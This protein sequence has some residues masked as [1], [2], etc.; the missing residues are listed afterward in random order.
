MGTTTNNGWTYPESTDLV[1][2]GATAIQ[3]LADAID[4]TLGVYAP[5]TS[6]LTLINTT[7][8]S[9]VA[10]QSL[11]AD[12]FTS[13]YRN[14]RMVL[15]ITAIS[16]VDSILGFR[17]RAGGADDTGA[18]YVSISQFINQTGGAG[19][20]ATTGGTLAYLTNLDGGNTGHNYGAVCDILNPKGAVQTLIIRQGMGVQQDG[21]TYQATIG[22]V[23]HNVQTAYDS[24]TLLTSSTTTLTGQIQIFGY[25]Q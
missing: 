5:S 13:T 14:Y 16:A 6:G 25:N 2:D 4:T 24:I 9:G 11:T 23:F 22:N 10:S 21:A 8:F 19:S 1:K 7:T 18:N 20:F 3:T 17:M 12:I 15:D